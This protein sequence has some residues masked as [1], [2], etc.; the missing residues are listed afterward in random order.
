MGD[1]R[2]SGVV[3]GVR[4]GGTSVSVAVDVSTIGV[5]VICSALD[6][7]VLVM[8]GVVGSSRGCLGRNGHR[9]NMERSEKRR[10]IFSIRMIHRL[11]EAY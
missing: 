10:K 6:G 8:G 9:D 2:I 4:V 1:G 5:G 7:E 3:V 11:N